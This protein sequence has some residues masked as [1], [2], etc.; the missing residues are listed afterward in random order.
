MDNR[1]INVKKAL[2]YQS[3]TDFFTKISNINLVDIRYSISNINLVDIRYSISNINLVDIRYSNV[4]ISYSDLNSRKKQ[5]FL[6]KFLPNF[7]Y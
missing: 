1:Y 7:E 5:I 3:Q 4:K 6:Y 2:K